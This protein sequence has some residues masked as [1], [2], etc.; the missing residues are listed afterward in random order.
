MGQQRIRLQTLE[1]RQLEEWVEG[2]RAFRTKVS[3][4]VPTK[5]CRV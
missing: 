4:L 5:S 2:N 1:D 3:P